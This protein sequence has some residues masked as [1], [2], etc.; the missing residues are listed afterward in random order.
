MAASLGRCGSIRAPGA[1]ADT[2]LLRLADGPDE[3]HRNQIGKLEIKRHRATDP[4]YTG[5]HAQVLSLAE[6]EE[7]SQAEAW[8]KR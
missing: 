8:R 4:A 5:G 2:R 6:V 3:V 1:L 7:I